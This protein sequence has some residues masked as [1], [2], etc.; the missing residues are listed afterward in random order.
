MDFKFVKTPQ[1]DACDTT[2]QE[3][4]YHLKLQFESLKLD[5]KEIKKVQLLFLYGDML[6]KM[7]VDVPDNENGDIKCDPKIYFVHSTPKAL[8][9]KFQMCPIIFLLINVENQKII[10]N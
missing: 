2:I 1:D 3:N 10:G 9:E 7:E 6:S 4:E 5:A 8:A